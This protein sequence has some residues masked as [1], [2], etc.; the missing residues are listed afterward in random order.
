MNNFWNPIK[1]KKKSNIFLAI[2]GAEWVPTEK[3]LRTRV[4]GEKQ[5]I[6]QKKKKLRKYF[7][8]QNVIHN[9]RSPARET[10]RIRV[11]IIINLRKS[12]MK[13]LC[14]S[15]FEYY[16]IIKAGLVHGVLRNCNTSR[17]RVVRSIINIHTNRLTDKSSR[18]RGVLK[19]GEKTK[20]RKKIKRNRYNIYNDRRFFSFFSFI[21]YEIDIQ[22]VLFDR[23][24]FGR[25][26][27][28]LKTSIIPL[29]EYIFFPPV[30]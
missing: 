17:R 22:F 4:V 10:L 29:Y 3:S 19:K 27:A 15:L 14:N 30:I 11:R 7:N 2:L 5:K 8:W 6:T 21:R 26:M 9:D 25:N 28:I 12:R 20:N 16:I 13:T 23:L 24:H 18:G 1:Q